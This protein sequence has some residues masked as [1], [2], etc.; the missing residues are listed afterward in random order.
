MAGEGGPGTDHHSPSICKILAS[1]ELKLDLQRSL[2]LHS[3]GAI[4][5]Q[6]ELV[7]S[8]IIHNTH[9]NTHK[10]GQK[11]GCFYELIITCGNTMKPQA[12]TTPNTNTSGYACGLVITGLRRQS[13]NWL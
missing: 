10:L 13:Q 2:K 9:A 1:S 12:N 3:R 6:K 7:L 8:L 11:G 4:S 5:H